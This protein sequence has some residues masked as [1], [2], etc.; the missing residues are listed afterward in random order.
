M[1]PFIYKAF[2]AFVALML[3]GSMGALT[4]YAQGSG[5]K[6]GGTKHPCS[7]T[8]NP[9]ACDSLDITVFDPN[10]DTRMEVVIIADTL[11]FAVVD[12]GSESVE[13]QPGNLMFMCEPGQIRSTQSTHD[14]VLIELEQCPDPRGLDPLPEG[15]LDSSVSF[16]TASGR[17]G[18]M[19]GDN[20]A[21]QWLNLPAATRDEQAQGYSFARVR[22]TITAR[23]R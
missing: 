21:E 11:Y 17:A 15:W 20:L 16:E 19:P 18:I 22:I 1:K 9:G 8:S 6:G 13:L 12:T 2:L 3:A 4:S 14:N 10:H 23:P 7:K 5:D